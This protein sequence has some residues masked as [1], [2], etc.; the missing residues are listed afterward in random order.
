MFRWLIQQRYL[1]A[2]SFAGIKVRGASRS[3]SLAVTRVFG[4]GEWSVIQ[5]VAEGLEWGHGW[6]A[7]AAQRLRFVLDFAYATGL[8]IGELV[9]A[10]LGQIEV[11]A[12]GDRWLHLVGKGSKAGKV[13]LPP[14]ARAA[15]DRYLM[16]RR[17]P[18]TPARWDPRTPLIGSLGSGR[19][20]RYHRYAAVECHAALFHEGGR[21]H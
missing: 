1:L 6:Q 4:E 17:L 7:P 15:L 16:Q 2:N 13:A 10:T 21:G 12:R 5:A 3:E 11:D 9:G 19:R 20:R 8:R 14:L 18:I